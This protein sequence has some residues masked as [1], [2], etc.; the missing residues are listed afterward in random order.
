LF[1]RK[2]CRYRV[3]SGNFRL[4]CAVARPIGNKFDGTRGPSGGKGDGGYSDDGAQTEGTS[5]VTIGLPSNII[6]ACALAVVFMG[7][8]VYL[9]TAVLKISYTIDK[10]LRIGSQALMNS[11][12]FNF[13]VSFGDRDRRGKCE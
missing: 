2:R 3:L 9:A 8:L 10:S 5:G 4:T 7:F 6:F 13:S 1:K 11:L 12:S